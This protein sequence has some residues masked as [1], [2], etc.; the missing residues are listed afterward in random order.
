MNRT[1]QSVVSDACAAIGLDPPRFRDAASIVLRVGAV[2]VTL[3][4]APDRRSLF[5]ATTAGDLARDEFT[6]ARQVD[7]ILGFAL[8][9]LSVSRACVSSRRA[10]DAA[11]IL[12]EAPHRYDRGTRDLLDAIAETVATH[13]GVEQFLESAPAARGPALETRE[14]GDPNWLVF[15]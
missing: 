4:E 1:F 5:V 6:R 12:V 7:S 14:S 13:E 8:A 15:R 3:R 10:A 2:D 9:Q 11:T